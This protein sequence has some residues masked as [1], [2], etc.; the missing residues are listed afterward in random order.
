M[1]YRSALE[2][3]TSLRE[4]CSFTNMERALY[5]HK[6]GLLFSLAWYLNSVSNVKAL[7]G[8]QPGE[9]PSRGLLRDCDTSRN[10]R[11][12]SSEAL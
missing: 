1:I 9:G 11:Q 10:L 2:L 3:E 7:V 8:F 5:R 4:V 6:I 12:P